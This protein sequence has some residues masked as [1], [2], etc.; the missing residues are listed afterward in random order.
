MQLLPRSGS[1]EEQRTSSFCLL[2]QLLFLGD[3]PLLF[4]FC[5]FFT[6][7]HL[8]EF[9]LQKHRAS[10]LDPV[11]EGVGGWGGGWGVCSGSLQGSDGL[12]HALQFT[13]LV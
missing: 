11:P 13:A 12:Q 10:A 7:K 9:H 2:L 6:D 8:Q 3:A 1:S 4:L 5:F